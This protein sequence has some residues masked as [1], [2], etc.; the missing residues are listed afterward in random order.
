MCPNIIKLHLVIIKPTPNIYTDRVKHLIMKPF[1]FNTYA[2]SPPLPP[3]LFANQ[4]SEVSKVS[5]CDGL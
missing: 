1:F 4:Q 5:I 2:L 3:S